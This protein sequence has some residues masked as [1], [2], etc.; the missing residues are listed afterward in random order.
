M[1]IKFLI[2]FIAAS[3][4]CSTLFAAQALLIDFTYPSFTGDFYVSG[5]VAFAPGIVK[6]ED[7]V[8]VKSHGTDEEIPTKITILQKWPDSSILSAEITFVANSARKESCEL[9]YGPEIRRKKIFTETAVLPTIS[10]SVG[11]LPKISEKVDID[12]G[13]INVRVDKSHG[14]Y[15]YWHAIPIVIFIALA[16][17][18]YRRTKKVK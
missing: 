5:N 14:L 1:R 15:Y 17:Y 13:Q 18:R 7:D 4:S 3:L 8:I 12:V 6:S 2:F 11:G 16:F 10:F 9:L